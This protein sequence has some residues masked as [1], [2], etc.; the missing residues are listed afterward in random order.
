M[1]D[2]NVDIGK[3][4]ANSIL[5]VGC[6]DVKT[7]WEFERAQLLAA[8]ATTKGLSE[9]HSGLRINPAAVQSTE[10]RAQCPESPVFILSLAWMPLLPRGFPLLPGYVL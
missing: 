8:G 3:V 10:H 2:V 5:P 9:N 4:C 7:K 1:Y 6:E